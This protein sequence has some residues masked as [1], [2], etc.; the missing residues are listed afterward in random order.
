MD[1]IELIPYGEEIAIRQEQLLEFYKRDQIIAI[2]N[3]DATIS[4]YDGETLILTAATEAFLNPKD[5][6]V[7]GLMILIKN[8]LMG[9]DT[10]YTPYP[11]VKVTDTNGNV[12]SIPA[13]GSFVCNP[14]TNPAVVTDGTTDINLYAG[15]TYTCEVPEPPSEWFEMEVDT[16]IVG[17]GSP[18]DTFRFRA[19]SGTNLIIDKGDGS[20]IIYF[21]NTG[22]TT[23]IDLVYS[24][25]GVYTVK[26]KGYYSG[27]FR[28]PSDD[29][30]KITNVLNMGKM[31]WLGVNA[32]FDCP[33]AI[34]SATD[35][36]ILI[37]NNPV[38]LFYK[39]TLLVTPPYINT[40]YISN[41]TSNFY[42]TS[43]DADLGYYDLRSCTNLTNFALDV[44]TW[45]QANYSATLLGWL[46]WDSNT[47]SPAVGWVL[48]SNVPF[49]GGNSTVAI[50]SEAALARTYLIN[51][52]GWTITDGGE[53]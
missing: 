35:Q 9:S 29:G 11:V 48:K 52:L 37:S 34:F 19:K 1:V 5:S 50:G 30:Y 18:S 36:M 27:S 3:E 40:S 20:D 13:G 41:M 14:F 26:M 12:N 21:T 32:F 47:H 16:T 53:V 7:K 4:L 8:M 17:A 42:R 15:Q 31:L 22:A 45:S 43:L 23:N 49:H 39:C 24:V 25:G 46:R 33:N 2:S 51:T 6:S 28:T 10:T 38:P 44:T